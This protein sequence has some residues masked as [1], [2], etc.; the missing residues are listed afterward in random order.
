M[1]L[2]SAGFA[3]CTRVEQAGPGTSIPIASGGVAGEPSEPGAS[4][5]GGGDAAGGEPSG[6]GGVP[7][8]L[9]LGLWPTYADDP[10]QPSEAQAVLAAVSALSIGSGTL[11]LSERWDAL[12]GSTGSPRLVTWNRLDA[13][14]K[15]YRE[16][17]KSVALCIDVVDRAGA[18]WPFEGELDTEAAESAMQRTIDEVLARYAGQL[19]HLCFGY[20][21]DR[22]WARVS[23]SSGR[24]LLEFLK[25]SIAYAS[26]HP[27]R[28]AST[29]IGAA[30]TLGA[31]TEAGGAPLDELLLG[32]EVVAVYDPLD[33]RARLKPP[34]SVG[35]EI[36]AALETL[37]SRP[38]VALPLALFEVGYPSAA[39][40][41]SSDEDQ[42]A[43]YEA[44]FEALGARRDALS[45]V[46]VFGLGDRAQA[47]C[48]AEAALFGGGAAAEAA[49]AVARC[50]MG[51]R[52]E[53]DKPALSGVLAAFSRFR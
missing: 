16:R 39:E 11:P 43:F 29:A 18:A 20:E 23:Q 45:F 30:I 5:A 15:P 24:R 9:E 44:L 17:G 34:S 49:R 40:A 52:A 28:S 12:S 38:G 2:A 4:V 27:R 31:L 26:Q 33:S 37:A 25:R 22:Y 10:Q 42:R 19:S 53:G 7:S 8:A 1:A 50:S 35:A 3:A 46:G 6:T 14:V 51:L 48:E 47:D 32:D 21:L 13:M 36:E 41:G